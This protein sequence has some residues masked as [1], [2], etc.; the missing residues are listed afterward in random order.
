MDLAA[1]MSPVLTMAGVA[2]RAAPKEI[3]CASR[4]SSN[5]ISRPAMAGATRPDTLT[6]SHSP[7]RSIICCSR[8]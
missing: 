3:A 6:L 5:P 4:F 2:A 7:L 1:E 8:A